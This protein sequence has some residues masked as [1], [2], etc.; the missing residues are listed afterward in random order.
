[1]Q[2]IASKR[3]STVLGICHV[4]GMLDMVA[5]PVWVGTLMEF[6]HLPPA[7]AGLTITIFLSG[8]VLASALTAR[9]FKRL[10]HRAVVATGFAIAAAAFGYLATVP[11]SAVPVSLLLVVHGIAGIAAGMS[12]SVTHGTIGRS[13]NPHR[14]FGLVNIALGVFGVA[15]FA[16]VPGLI[17]SVGPQVL[18][19]VFAGGLAV[20]ALIAALSF[21]SLGTRQNRVKA[22]IQ[23]V[24]TNAWLL[25]F[26]VVC[27]TFNQA[28]LF[29]FLERIG[30]HKGFSHDDVGRVL[31]ILGFVNL[32]PGALAAMAQKRLS[33]TM[34]GLA[35]PILQ[36][37]LALVVVN[38]TGFATYATFAIPY[39][40]VV[41]FTHTFIFGLLSQIDPSGRAVAATPAMMMTGSALGPAVGG[42]VVAG[43]GYEGLG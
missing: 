39:V 30:D 24:P 43:F 27:L 17:Q 3:A 28:T 41:I 36:V 29:S 31:I 20:A 42:A 13:I 32:L 16:A 19:Q 23:P 2:N 6:Y 33:P 1:M 15:F 18:F 7:Q 9:L 37:L 35:G 14:L 22:T 21:P 40:F 11:A 25:I 5:L 10:N 8:V 34:V 26:V 4:A 38:A 12:L